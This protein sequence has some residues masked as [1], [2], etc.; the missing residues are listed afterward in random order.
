MIPKKLFFIWLIIILF[1]PLTISCFPVY[2]YRYRQSWKKSIIDLETRIVRE[3]SN[4]LSA[5]VLYDAEDMG[6]ME[7]NILIIFKDNQ[8]LNISN[9][10]V[11]QD[12]IKIVAVNGYR[13]CHYSRRKDME[14]EFIYDKDL[15][16]YPRIETILRN[17]LDM[18]FENIN[19]IIQ[20]FDRIV[21]YMDS[22]EDINSEKYQ[23]K[24]LE[25]LWSDEADLERI[26]MW[27]Y[28]DRAWTSEGIIFKEPYTINDPVSIFGRKIE[29]ESQG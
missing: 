22:L 3:N 26:K 29:W 14:N 4:V 6:P 23:S 25:W 28:Q 27:N 9:V 17:K 16:Y 2:V 19:Q 7:L 1:S 12:E 8:W 24:S 15:F 11:K 5:Y 10:T 18:R 20:N 21:A 13:I